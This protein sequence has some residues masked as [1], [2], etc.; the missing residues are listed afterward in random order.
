[1]TCENTENMIFFMEN[2]CVDTFSLTATTSAANHPITE[3]QNPSRRLTWKSTSLASNS[4]QGDWTTP[5]APETNL[6]GRKFGVV[7]VNHN[8]PET[9]GGDFTTIRVRL[10]DDTL[11]LKIDESFTGVNYSGLDFR[12]KSAIDQIRPYKNRVIYISGDTNFTLRR[13]IITL[14]GVGTLAGVTNWQI[15]RLLLGP[16]FQASENVYYENDNLESVD[17][18]RV[19]F[20]KGG[21]QFS[22]YGPKRRGIYIEPPQGIVDKKQIVDWLYLTH[23]VGSRDPVFVD[24]HPRISGDFSSFEI[25]EAYSNL[26]WQVY[27][28]ANNNIKF[29]TKSRNVISASG[30]MTII[31][32]A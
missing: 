10:Y 17:S 29:S 8:F 11:T 27:G 25:S 2:G 26:L 13:W 22:D 12:S 28:I 21:D 23:V 9:I 32:Q 4:I 1:M 7:F 15:G 6:V 3:V 14:S 18:S 16:V 20:S 5:I 24:L 19:N 31:E 30:S